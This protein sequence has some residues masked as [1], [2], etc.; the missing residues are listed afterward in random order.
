M[1][2]DEQAH[3]IFARVV[4]ETVIV[5]ETDAVFVTM[6]S[7]LYKWDDPSFIKFLTNRE[8]IPTWSVW[9]EFNIVDEIVTDAMGIRYNLHF[10]YEVMG[11]YLKVWDVVLMLDDDW[12][13]W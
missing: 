10:A 11:A 8:L 4:A 12:C 5:Y 1:L 3:E 6:A 9:D 7:N 13:N 2:T